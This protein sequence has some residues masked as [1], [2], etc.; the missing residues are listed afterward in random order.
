MGHQRLLVCVIPSHYQVQWWPVWYHAIIRYNDDLC[1]TMP[2]S[3]TMMTC[4]IPCHYQVQWWPVWYH[5]IIRYNDDLCDTKPLSGTMMTCVIP[6][7][8]QVQ[9]WPIVNWTLRNKQLFVSKLKCFLS[10]IFF[11]QFLFILFQSLLKFVPK[12][13][14]D[15]KSSLVQEIVWCLTGDKPLSEPMVIKIYDV[16]L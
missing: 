3:G 12:G 11:M 8:Y 5:A 16:R 1:D 13:P 14:I 9:W 2:L 7:H 15:N 6:C 10:S 4:V